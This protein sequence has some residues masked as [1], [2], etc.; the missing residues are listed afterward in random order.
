MN[1]LGLYFVWNWNKI[2]FFLPPG[3]EKP[4]PAYAI[5]YLFSIDFSV[6]LYIQ[7]FLNSLF[8]L[9]AYLFTCA[10]K[11]GAQLL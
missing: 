11:P 2:Q 5:A 7:I 1:P 10:L 6:P 4:K 3:N 8:Y 9:L